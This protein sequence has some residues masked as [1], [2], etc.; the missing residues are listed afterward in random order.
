MSRIRNVISHLTLFTA[1]AFATHSSHAAETLCEGDLVEKPIFS[2]QIKKKTVSICKSVD[3]SKDKGYLKYRYGAGP[4]KLDLE[5]PDDKVKPSQVFKFGFETRGNGAVEWLRVIRGDHAYV[6]YTDSTQK[7][8]SDAGLRVYKGDKKIA[9]LKCTDP[10][11]SSIGLLDG[12]VPKDTIDHNGVKVA[13]GLPDSSGMAQSNQKFPDVSKN[14]E[15][16]K[17]ASVNKP[18][19]KDDKS[20]DELKKIYDDYA[21]L[22]NCYESRKGYA[23]I[24]LTQQEYDLV[25]KSVKLREA[26]L[27]NKNSELIK[28]KEAIWGEVSKKNSSP[29][30]TNFDGGTR[31][32][33]QMSFREFVVAQPMKK[34][35]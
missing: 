31:S 2:C 28:Q 23:T 19:V 11:I 22:K 1:L 32:I 6:V 3:L 7:N 20:T 10:E 15:T 30:M 9:D 35:F 16:V 26:E 29:L 12:I 24:Y 21:F 17:A 33:C 8:D 18:S 27:L 13:S 14:I 5:F 25:L 4:D 34:D